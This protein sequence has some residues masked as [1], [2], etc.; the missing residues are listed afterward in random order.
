MVRW[1]NIDVYKATINKVELRLPVS[2]ILFNKEHPLQLLFQID[3]HRHYSVQIK[4]HPVVISS[5]DTVLYRYSLT[6]YHN[7][8]IIPANFAYTMPLKFPAIYYSEII[9]MIHQCQNLN[10][11]TPR[12]KTWPKK[13]FKCI[14]TRYLITRRGRKG[15]K[16]KEITCTLGQS[17]PA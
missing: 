11:I 10:I 4:Y 12:F 17:S 6:H 2:M 9:P 14:R 3:I 15:N 13:T 16:I 8:F 7:H 5:K 1:P